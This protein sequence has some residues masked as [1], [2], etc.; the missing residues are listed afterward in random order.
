MI[1]KILLS[2]III[3]SLFNCVSGD[4]QLNYTD[5]FDT[6]YTVQISN[7]ETYQ[8][9]T[10]NSFDLLTV[11][12]TTVMS[13]GIYYNNISFYIYDNEYTIKNKYVVTSSLIP[14]LYNIEH[15]TTVYNNDVFRTEEINEYKTYKICTSTFKSQMFLGSYD[16]ID[17]TTNK[18][19]MEQLISGWTGIEKY[20]TYVCDIQQSDMSNIRF[21]KIEKNTF[22]TLI[23]EI[24]YKKT[25]TY[26]E[27]YYINQ[28]SSPLEFI[29]KGVKIIDSDKSLL[30][31]ML[32]CEYIFSIV[33]FIIGVITK[34]FFTILILFLIAGIP[35]I[36]LSNSRGKNQFIN[37][38]ISYYI[39]TFNIMISFLTGSI[40][41]A[42]KIIEIVLPF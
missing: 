18:I 27:Q 3:F 24:D 6:Y 13:P 28:L 35:T 25:G 11:F 16:E 8:L 9:Y 14:I 36:A 29:Y 42:L 5:T 41:I 22:S 33:I 17:D 34:S 38:C 32:L 19:Y 39:I 7:N 21:L 20:Y 1:N 40:K 10:D 23:I 2:I 26:S 15:T 30:N 37:K 4:M 31:I 12:Q